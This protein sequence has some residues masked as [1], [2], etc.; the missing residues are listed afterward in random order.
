MAAAAIFQRAMH[1]RDWLPCHLGAW[2]GLCLLRNDVKQSASRSGRALIHRRHARD[3]QARTAGFKDESTGA[4][5][6]TAS[7]FGSL[8]RGCRAAEID[9]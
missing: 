9:P 5:P 8:A 3:A 6:Y 4:M 2:P 7:R 1:R